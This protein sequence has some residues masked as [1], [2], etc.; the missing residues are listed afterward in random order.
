LYRTGASPVLDA[1]TIAFVIKLTGGATAF[2]LTNADTI[3]LVGTGTG[4][5]VANDTTLTGTAVSS[6][7]KTAGLYTGSVTLN[8]TY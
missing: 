4:S 5:A 8:I 1:D 2:T 3:K 7:G 6:T